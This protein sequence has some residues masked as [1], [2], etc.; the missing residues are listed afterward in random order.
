MIDARACKSS[1]H[2]FCLEY[3]VEQAKYALDVNPDEQGFKAF[4]KELTKHALIKS[5][6][7]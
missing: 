6:H 1:Y 3:L 7:S 5:P 2:A 4:K